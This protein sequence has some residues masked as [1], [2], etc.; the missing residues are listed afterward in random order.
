[1][2]NNFAS[3]AHSLITVS[4]VLIVYLILT[5]SLPILS[6]HPTLAGGPDEVSDKGSLRNAC[7]GF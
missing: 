1:M 5:N 4:Q 6:K 7:A 3:Q 2:V